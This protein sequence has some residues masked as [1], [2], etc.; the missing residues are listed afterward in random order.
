MGGWVGGGKRQGEREAGN[1][2]FQIF[3]YIIF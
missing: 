1:F 3:I 2:F